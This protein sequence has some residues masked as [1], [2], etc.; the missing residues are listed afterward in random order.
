MLNIEEKDK[1]KEKKGNVI[2]NEDLHNNHK[3]NTEQKILRIPDE[4]KDKTKND[5]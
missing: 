1:N 5:L 4:K 3:Q 2:V